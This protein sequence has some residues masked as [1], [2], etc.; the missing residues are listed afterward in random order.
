M[1]VPP[2]AGNETNTAPIPFGAARTIG[3]AVT[4]QAKGVQV[5]REGDEIAGGS[6]SERLSGIAFPR[7]EP[8][9]LANR[10]PDHVDSGGGG[11]A[12][13]VSGT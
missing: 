11:V 2:T 6:A 12:Q 9:R 7:T 8:R 4:V 13:A 5:R 3:L 1:A 10:C